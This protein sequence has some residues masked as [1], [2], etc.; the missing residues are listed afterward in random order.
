MLQ[1]RKPQCR[2][3]GRWPTLRHD[4][5]RRSTLPPPD[6]LPRQAILAETG[7]L[8]P[9]LPGEVMQTPTSA[10]DWDTPA[11]NVAADAPGAITARNTAARPACNSHAIRQF[12]RDI[13]A[14]I[15]E[16]LPLIP[17]WALS[18]CWIGVVSIISTLFLRVGLLKETETQHR[19]YPLWVKSRHVRCKTACPL[20]AN[21][22]HRT[23]FDYFVG[24]TQQGR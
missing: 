21:S 23:S 16:A 14:S 11:A 18:R 2:Y 8:D 7:L 20:S 1:S 22:G 17:P 15:L 24:C 4:Q 3:P 19:M 10:P 9:V 13:L 5:Q 6:P 12:E